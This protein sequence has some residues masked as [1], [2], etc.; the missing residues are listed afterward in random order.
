MA[1]FYLRQ[2]LVGR[3]VGK[4]SSVGRQMQNFVYLVGDR[5]RGEC[6]A[7]DPAWDVKG[8][9]EVAAADGMK[10]VGAFATHYHPD[11]VG[12]GLFGF[13]VQGL[14]DLLELQSCPVHTH[15][16]EA[17]GLRKVTGISKT[18]MTLHDSG[19]TIRVGEIEIEWLHTPG[20]TPGSSCFR[21]KDAL[22][23]GDTLFLQGCGRVDL[24]GGDPEEM[25]RTLTQRLSRLPDE[26]VLYPGHAYGGEH[27]PLG[28]VR[29]T[30]PYFPPPAPEG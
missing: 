4:T 14:P 29:K 2:L 16:L 11:H 9:L 28:T 25:R 22:I 26:V 13:G 1:T 20:H 23:A 3:D 7:V 5:D 8:V 18:D 6:I 21:V 27:A 24:P 15:K 10:L 30:N 12:G 17:D 19:D